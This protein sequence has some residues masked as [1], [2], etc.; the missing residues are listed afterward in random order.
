MCRLL[1]TGCLHCTR[2]GRKWLHDK[3][4]FRRSSF[5]SRV[6]CYLEFLFVSRYSLVNLILHPAVHVFKKRERERERERAA[7]IFINLNATGDKSYSLFWVNR[8]HRSVRNTTCFQRKFYIYVFACTRINLT[9]KKFD[10]W[11]KC[12]STGNRDYFWTRGKRWK[13]RISSRST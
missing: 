1:E 12:S 6:N 3:V 7:M 2:R 11:W 5:A 13:E 4:R 8:C 10:T 9:W